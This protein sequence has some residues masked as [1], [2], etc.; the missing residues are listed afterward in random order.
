MSPFNL[1]ASGP[2][3]FWRSLSIGGNFF[4]AGSPTIA[5][6]IVAFSS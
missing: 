1:P 2:K 6:K 5:G 3:A 4:E